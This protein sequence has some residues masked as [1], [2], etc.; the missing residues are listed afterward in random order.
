MTANYELRNHI[1]LS[2]RDELFFNIVEEKLHKFGKKIFYRK[3]RATVVNNLG[4][5]CFWMKKELN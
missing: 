2:F 4:I 1:F 5:F 3:K